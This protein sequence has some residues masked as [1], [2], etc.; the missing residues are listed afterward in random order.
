MTLEPVE[1]KT[2][3]NTGLI[4][5]FRRWP[6]IFQRDKLMENKEQSLCSRRGSTPASLSL[7][8]CGHLRN[9]RIIFT[10]IP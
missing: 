10:A 7:Q 5:R 8:I 3:R 9:L 4:H 2:Q 6:Q 1:T